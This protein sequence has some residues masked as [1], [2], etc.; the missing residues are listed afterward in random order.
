VINH[1][2]RQGACPV[3]RVYPTREGSTFLHR[4]EGE[5][6]SSPSCGPD[7]SGGPTMGEPVGPSLGRVM[8]RPWFLRGT[9]PFSGQG[10]SSSPCWERFDCMPTSSGIATGSWHEGI[11]ATHLL[12]TICP[13]PLPAAGQGG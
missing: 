5:G 4:P 7:G 12:A 10:A 13:M 9:V 2:A 11:R 8:K 3:A 1:I 6:H